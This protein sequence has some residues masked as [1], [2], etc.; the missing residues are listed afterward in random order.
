[1]RFYPSLCAALLLIS[2]TA[3]Q[4]AELAWEVVQPFRFLR[5]QSDHRIHELAFAEAARDA[6][7]SDR[8]VSAMEALLNDPDWWSRKLESIDAAPAEAIEAMR[9]EEG[10]Q[11]ETVDPRLG[12]SSLLRIRENSSTGAGTCW[13][14]TTQSFFNCFSDPGNIFGANDYMFPRRHVVRLSVKDGTDPQPACTFTVTGG[15][16]E[17]A[18]LL[19]DNRL[20]Q[21]RELPEIAFD[22]CPDQV[23][24]RVPFEGSL[25]IEVTYDG[26]VLQP[27]TVKVRDFVV[28]S[29]GDSFASGE[30]NPDLPATL[31]TQRSIRPRYR[32][33]ENGTKLAD[34][35]VPRRKSRGDG[36]IAPFSSARWV[37]RR[38]HRSMYSPHARAAIALAL[39]GDRHH[40]VTYVSFACSG[41]EITDGV[42]WPQDG[43]ECTTRGSAHD[44][45]LEPQIG[46]LVGAL[47]QTV[48]SPKNPRSFPNM[49]HRRDAF[50]RSHLRHGSAREIRKRNQ[51]CNNWP[52]FNKIRRNPRL[53]T[54]LL[55]REIDVLFI[56]IGGNDMGF[57]P[58]V[59]S[60]VM[61][62]GATGSLFGD[63]MAPV[64]RMAAGGISLEEA[65][66]RIDHLSQRFAM[67]ALAFER[68]LEIDDASRVIM[69]LYPSPAFDEEGALCDSGRHG[70]NASRLFDLAGPS[71][72]HTLVTI[73]EAQTVVERLNDTIRQHGA[74]H[75]FTIVESFLDRFK[76][77]G[78]CAADAGADIAHEKLDLPFRPK[79]G[80]TWR[81]F[82]PVDDFY[83]YAKR[84]R[85]FRTFNDSFLLMQHFK[86][87]AY[88]EKARDRGNAFYLAFRT[89]GGPVHPTA[90]GH[91]AIADSLY[92]AAA[93]KLLAGQEGA[94]CG[95]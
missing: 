83:P 95:N 69:S 68:K 86:G 12:W 36:T 51:F 39:S 45:F 22:V 85:W 9:Q 21:S 62:R 87:A 5:F 28:A 89:L 4:A 58:L 63:L 2:S 54:A 59:T 84:Q 92:C 77:H 53:R 91:A 44:R 35:G 8:R 13:N 26:A 82:H 10:R 55:K 48:G 93:A 67:L 64:Y 94:E 38:C 57:A 56:S 90:E 16:V 3:L 29:M 23:L 7:F 30:G 1:M 37:D 14:A 88:D 25:T 50:N 65:N 33:D 34:F 46:A 76:P 43:R 73:G 41:A 31:D 66:E 52:G 60:T 11:P 75:G 18:G 20:V 70:M 40:A 24:A 78:I 74:A 71:D 61:T 81:V 42:F 19:E 6:E 80:D 72:D 49:L 32:P 15:L 47:G 17:G 27:V 79:G